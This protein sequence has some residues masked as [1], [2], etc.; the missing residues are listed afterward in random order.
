MGRAINSLPDDTDLAQNL[1]K[2]DRYL[3][4]QQVTNDF[5]KRWATEVTPM[6]VIRQK[7]HRQNRNLLPG[8]I[9]LVHDKNQIKGKYTLAKVEEVIFSHDGVV[10]SCVVSYRLPKNTDQIDQ[11][12]G[13]RLIK[14]KRSVQRLTLLLKKEDQDEQL[15]VEDDKIVPKD[16]ST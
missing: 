2:A 8:D 14:I 3:L 6:H 4:I 10:R 13:G 9:V 16:S 1:K 12:T 5:W 7:W 11:Y 15:V